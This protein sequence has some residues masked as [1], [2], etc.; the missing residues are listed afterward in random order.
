MIF[1]SSSAQG[2]ILGIRQAGVPAS[3]RRSTNAG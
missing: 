2:P 1:A 3:E